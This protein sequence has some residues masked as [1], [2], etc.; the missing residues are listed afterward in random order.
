MPGFWDASAVV[1]LCVAAQNAGH[2]RQLLHQHAPVVWWGTAIEAVSA[3]VR[4]RRQS[5]L[6]EAQYYA[7]DKRLTALRRTWREIQPTNRVKEFGDIQLD[8]YALRP[9]ASLPLPPP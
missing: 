6:T 3:L 4:L 1:P 2:D 7:A 8:P 9:P 5:F